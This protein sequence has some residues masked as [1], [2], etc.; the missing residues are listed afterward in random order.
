M[1][2]L[3]LR[4]KAQPPLLMTM[5][6]KREFRDPSLPSSSAAHLS[7]LATWNSEQR[8]ANGQEERW[9]GSKGAQTRAACKEVQ[10]V[11]VSDGSSS[12]S[13]GKAAKMGNNSLEWLHNK[14]FHEA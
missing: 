13:W 2:A 3:E 8:T 1:N 12:A 5:C 14:A 9:C 10:E 11:I 6:R 4:I 7:K